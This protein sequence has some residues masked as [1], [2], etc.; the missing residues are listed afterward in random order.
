V[1]RHGR[2]PDRKGADPD[3]HAVTGPAIRLVMG[4]VAGS[5]GLSALGFAG[6]GGPDALA[7]SVSPVR[8]GGPGLTQTEP[9]LARPPHLLFRDGPPARVTG[10]FGEDSCYACHW[11][12]TENDETGVLAVHG[13][14]GAYDPG[15]AYDLEVVLA[16]PGMAVAGFQLATRHEGDGSQA[17][18]L[19]VPADETQRVTVLVER[20]IHFAQHLLPGTQLTSPDTARW[21][22]RWT[23]PEEPHAQVLLHLSAVAGDG[24]SS[25]MGDAV[26][27]LE[28][29]SRP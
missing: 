9:G 29:Q 12:G 23:A 21:M 24:D 26:Y 27:T 1:V 5:L 6:M 8:V 7:S 3:R 19:G 14:P 28:L 20:E 11:E 18:E 16:R 10:G 15:V 2:E 17:G 13:F 25:Q 4:S 22:V